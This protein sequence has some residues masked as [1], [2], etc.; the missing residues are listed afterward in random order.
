MKTNHWGKNE[1]PENQ[2]PRTKNPLYNYRNLIL[3]KKAQNLTLAIIRELATMPQDRFVEIVSD[4]IMR[5]SCSMGA[6]IAEGHGRFSPGAHANYLSIAKASACETDN[7]L[8]LLRRSGHLSPE[9]EAQLH[10]DCE[11][12]IRMLTSKI[13]D[14]RRLSRSGKPRTG[15]EPAIYQTSDYATEEPVLG[16]EF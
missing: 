11:E 10:A 2:E 14:L 6:N 13:L 8:D 9:V 5:S 16:S 7:F 1:M 15:E 3:W 4:Q 12:V